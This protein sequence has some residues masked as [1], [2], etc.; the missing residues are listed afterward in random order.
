MYINPLKVESQH[1]WIRGAG[2]VVESSNY[3]PPQKALDFQYGFLDT[4][5]PSMYTPHSTVAYGANA[6]GSD[7]KVDSHGCKS[8]ASLGPAQTRWCESQN[9]CIPYNNPCVM[10]IDD[11]VIPQSGGSGLTGFISAIVN[12]IKAFISKLFGA[13]E[14]LF[15][16]TPV[17][18][19]P[20]PYH[21]MSEMRQR[22]IPD[23]TYGFPS[24][25]YY[26]T[27]VVDSFRDRP[28][29]VTIFSRTIN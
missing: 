12:A 23:G 16:S 20:Y 11:A 24:R 19:A 29:Q 8:G 26:T 18:P 10:S 14:Q 13:G 9:R 7:I 4:S 27:E 22:M 1:S 25:T 2:S 21:T 5:G 15:G 6:G 17:L 3:C 28:G